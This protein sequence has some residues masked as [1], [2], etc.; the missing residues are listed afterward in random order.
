MCT[1][2]RRE[3]RRWWWRGEG[4]HQHDEDD[5]GYLVAGDITV[6]VASVR[7]WRMVLAISV[8]VQREGN[9]DDAGGARGGR[10]RSAYSGHIQR[11]G[12]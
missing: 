4:T 2:T 3:G 10:A 11:V 9:S 7:V 1:C 12:I 5:A 8:M 6:V